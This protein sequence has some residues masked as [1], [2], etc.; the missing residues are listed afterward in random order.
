MHFCI[1]EELHTEYWA[2]SKTWRQLICKAVKCSLILVFLLLSPLHGELIEI[3][4][5][6][7]LAV[8]LLNQTRWTIKEVQRDQAKDSSYLIILAVIAC[9]FEHV[10]V[11]FATSPKF[12]KAGDQR[13]RLCKVS[14]GYFNLTNFNQI[15]PSK[16][17]CK[18]KQEPISKQQIESDGCKTLIGSMTPGLFTEF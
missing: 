2:G 13:V 3:I 7:S 12:I 6:M 5:L 15:T 4:F 17:I 8:S 1:L 16:Q 9:F 10:S 11:I 18:S 14:K